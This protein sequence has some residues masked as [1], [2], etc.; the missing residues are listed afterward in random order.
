MTYS[1]RSD[2]HSSSSSKF[3][4]WTHAGHGPQKHAPHQIDA[5]PHHPPVVWLQRHRI[6]QENQHCQL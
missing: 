5:P 6:A 4:A 1:L 2:R 3:Q